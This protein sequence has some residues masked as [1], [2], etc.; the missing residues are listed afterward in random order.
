MRTFL[1]FLIVLLVLLVGVDFGARYLADRQIAD[2]VQTR[3]D[4]TDR[5]DV[6]IGG[7]PFLVQA[8]E[9][10]YDSITATLPPSTVG[11]L[12]GVGATLVLDGVRIPLGD[13][14]SGNVDR[15]TADGSRLRLSVPTASI[16]DAAGLPGLTITGQDGALVLSATITVLGQQFPVTARLDAAVTDSSLVLRSGDVSGAGIT[17]PSEVLGAVSTLIDLTVPLDGL[18]VRV[19]SGGVTVVGTDLVVDATT[20]ALDLS[21]R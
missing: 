1:G 2:A 5:P 15:L 20:A 4:L 19:T 21:T 13:A 18:P 17:L 6:S 16:A 9:G 8:V 12:S 14:L 7:F 11:P 3:L 10:S